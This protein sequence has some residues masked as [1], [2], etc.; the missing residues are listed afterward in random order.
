MHR[1]PQIGS[2]VSL[3][4]QRELTQSARL[5]PTVAEG[6]LFEFLE[7]QT[8]TG[9]FFGVGVHINMQRPTEGRRNDQDGNLGPHRRKATPPE[10]SSRRSKPTLQL[11]FLTLTVTSL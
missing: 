6:D 11:E 10:L 5:S 8:P 4:I 7:K 2:T 1:G 3:R 9:S